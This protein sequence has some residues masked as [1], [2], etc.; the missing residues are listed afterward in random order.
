MGL[1]DARARCVERLASLVIPPQKGQRS[2]DDANAETLEERVAQR[3]FANAADHGQSAFH[4]LAEDRDDG[5]Q[6][7]D[8]ANLQR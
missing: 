4:V 2:D 3:L 8:V 1:Q 6:Q 7:V 5:E